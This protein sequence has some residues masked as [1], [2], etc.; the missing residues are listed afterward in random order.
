MYVCM[1]VYVCDSFFNESC[2]NFFFFFSAQRREVSVY[3]RN[4]K[5]AFMHKIHLIVQRG[6]AEHK[7]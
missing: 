3:P 5:Y 1:C 2:F 4:D 7:L 6:I